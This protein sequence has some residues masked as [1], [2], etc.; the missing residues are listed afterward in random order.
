MIQRQWTVFIL[1]FGLC[2]CAA[3]KPF[4]VVA[5][6]ILDLRRQPHT[7]AVPGVHDPLEETQLLY[8]EQVRLLEVRDGWAKIEA[9]EQAEYTS[10]GRWQ[11]YPGW[12]PARK[13]VPLAAVWQPNI[14]VT[15]KWAQV[16]EDAAMLRQ[17]NFAFA[18]GTM[19]RG[20]D[21]GGIVW[22]IE[23]VDGKI[24]WMDHDSARPLIEL[25]ALPE[26]E[27]RRVILKTAE[28]FLGD[29]YYWGGRSPSGNSKH[30]GITGVD[31]S[32]LVNLSYRSIGLAI[33]RDAHE[34]Y[35]RSRHIKAVQPG[36]LIFLSEAN[37]PKR[38]VHVMLYA[39]NGE[40]IE[41]PGTGKAVH[42]I[43]LTERFGQ[44]L[45]WITPGTVIHDQTIYFGSYLE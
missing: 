5:Q 25:H 23:L 8:G 14:V 44:T 16:F 40:L 21:M 4:M 10:T 39:G 43:R 12:V 11:G 17:V 24:A 22:R 27:K 33:P 37:N 42:R 18:L 19:L 1:A 41:G 36:D 38:I 15:E 20:T 30:A 2:G 3:S 26:S 34:Q 29:P 6:P 7:T 28:L 32:G 35:L 9:M 31:C 13:L 45:D